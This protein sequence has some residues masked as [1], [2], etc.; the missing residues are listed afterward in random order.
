[1]LPVFS[2]EKKMFCEETWSILDNKLSIQLIVDMKYDKK[3]ITKKKNW[4]KLLKKGN[5]QNYS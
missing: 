5:F 4:F 1:M 3:D 2:S